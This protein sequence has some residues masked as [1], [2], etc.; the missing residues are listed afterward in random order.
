VLLFG[1][2]YQLFP[3][4]KEGAIQGTSKKK[5]KMPQT[6]TA[7]TSASQLLCQR[8]NY[9]FTNVMS[10]TVF[11]LDKNYRVKNKEFQDLLGRLRTGEPTEQDA[12]IILT[13]HIG[14]YESDSIFMDYLKNNKK[15]M[16]L[17]ALNAEKEHKNQEMLI[18]TS[19]KMSVPGARLDCTYDTKRLS[20]DKERTVC[21][22]HF[23]QN[24]YD[25]HT[26]ICVGAKVA[27]SN[28]NFLPEIGLYNGA[29]GDVIEIVFNDRPVG[30]NDKQHCHLPNYVVV[31][32]PNLRLPTNIAPWDE[33]H[34]TVSST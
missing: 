9:L 16:W 5:L 20:G 15:T 11:T 22:S 2:D 13:L 14:L 18:N 12:E 4:I 6:P 23:D 27:I 8:G 21:Y 17:Y 10:G 32:F 26:D 30:P 1:D 31:D 7:K 3:V 25:Q 33:L 34:K 24:S 28:V 29:I 19:K